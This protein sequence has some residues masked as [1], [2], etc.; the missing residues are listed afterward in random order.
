MVNLQVSEYYSLR[1]TGR[2][3][4][5]NQYIVVSDTDKPRFNNKDIR[6][7][8]FGKL[9]IYAHSNLNVTI[10]FSHK[11]PEVKILLLGYIIDPLKP[12]MK[13]DGIVEL[14]A[15]Q[16]KSTNNCFK[17]IQGYTG[18]YVLLIKE[19]ASFVITG[20]ACH[21]RQIYFRFDGDK[22]TVTSSLKL[23]LDFYGYKLQ[24]SEEKIK[25]VNTPLHRKLQMAWYGH[26]SID[27]RLDKLLPNHYLDVHKK[28]VKR[29]PLFTVYNGKEDD[30]LIYVSSMLTGTY[31]ALSKRYQLMQPLTAGWDSRILLAA[32]KDVKDQIKYYVFGNPD[33]NNDDI[34]IPMNLSRSLDL[35]FKIVERKALSDN[36][37]EAYKKEH[38]IP[39][40]LPK[41]S[42]INY[43]YDCKYNENVIN[44]NG[45]CAEIARCFY[46]YTRNKIMLDMLL[47]FSKYYDKVPF[48]KERIA[49]WYANAIP[50]AK[51]YNI[52]LLDLFY[53]EQRMGNWGA[54]YP[55]ELDIAMEEISP[56]NNRSLLLALQSVNPKKR[57]SPKFSLFRKLVCKLWQDTLCEPV[58]PDSKYL[59]KII[60]GNSYLLY[61]IKKLAL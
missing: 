49:E 15:R 29:L 37:L 60:K 32:S 17:M 11:D 57:K 13:N 2:Q 21:L 8:K 40:I 54:Q 61:L 27:D 52:F 46:G 48:F 25:I 33:N 31:S 22:L 36:F 24:S 6:L 43:H 5:K 44:V 12:E 55:F 50:Y 28:E 26:E 30:V 45:N 16:Y 20:D 1:M 38:I 42:N 34:R 51:Q 14:I 19:K 59:T 18:R 35:N 23:F 10:A 41:T 56:F 3:M 39:R 9:H 53:W 7:V 58:N 47:V 4:Y